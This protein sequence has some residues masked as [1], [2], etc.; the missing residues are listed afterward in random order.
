MKE[1][2]ICERRSTKYCFQKA[3][4]WESEIKSLLSQQ[5]FQVTAPFSGPYPAEH[6]RTQL[7]ASNASLD[8]AQRQRASRRPSGRTLWTK[9]EPSGVTSS[10]SCPEGTLTKSPTAFPEQ[11]H[12]PAATTIL[13]TNA[14]TS[15]D[16]PFPVWHYTLRGC[17]TPA[18]LKTQHACHYFAGLGQR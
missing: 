18:N 5:H 6:L 3:P 9:Q 7:S 2:L 11:Q 16:L 12:F 8:K 14:I 17:Q 1:I 10:M 4:S 15:L 13:S